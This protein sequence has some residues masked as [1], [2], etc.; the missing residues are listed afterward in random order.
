MALVVTSLPSFVRRDWLELFPFLATCCPDA[1]TPLA[2]AA[3]S[4]EVPLVGALA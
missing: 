4:R 1:Y 3:W 2:A